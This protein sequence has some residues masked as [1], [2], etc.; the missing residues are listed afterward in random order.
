MDSARVRRGTFIFKGLLYDIARATLIGFNPAG[1]FDEKNM[2]EF[3]LDPGNWKLTVTFNRFDNL[4][5]QGSPT[6]KDRLLLDSLK[7]PF[8]DSIR[9]AVATHL[10]TE[11]WEKEQLRIDS[12][13][14][15]QHPNSWLAATLLAGY[16]Y[17]AI[18]FPSLEVLYDRL[19][20]AI[21]NSGPGQEIKT[22]VDQEKY[23]AIGRTAYDFHAL[24][25]GGDSIRLKD[26]KGRKY[27]L[28]DFWASWCIPCR[29]C[30]PAVKR[31]RE[32]YRDDLEIISISLKD[33]DS[34]WRAA[35]AKDKMDWPQVLSASIAGHYYVTTIPALVLI[36]KE[37]KIAGKY[38]G[39][40]RGGTFQ[41]L[42]KELA[43]GIPVA[44]KR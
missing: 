24:T 20:P 36:D 13:Y 2:K 27:I 32:K 25:A 39:W 30:T 7:R 38:D 1:S 18:S 44:G 14:I 10:P 11:Q 41:D 42:E 37:G 22:K 40:Y 33:T 35:I 4:R 43:R 3:Y 6:D 21:R 31:L 26:L 8:R 19:P 5:V 9:G 16:S 29:Q 12:L 23:L 15:L 34:S 17:Q 28:L